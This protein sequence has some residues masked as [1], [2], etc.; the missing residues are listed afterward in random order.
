MYGKPP[1]FGSS[2][3]CRITPQAW[4][5]WTFERSVEEVA[6]TLLGTVTVN[7]KYTRSINIE[8]DAENVAVLETYLPT[9]RS[10]QTLGAIGSFSAKRCNAAGIC[11]D[12]PYGSGKS[13]FSLYLSHLLSEPSSLAVR[14]QCR[15]SNGNNQR[16][17]TFAGATKGTA[18]IV[19]FC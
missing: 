1:A 3:A 2:T 13:M 11:S 7:T 5:D 19:R 16:S 15:S 9:S 12:G 14:R 8:R 4:L 10:V 18:A 6:A 17:L